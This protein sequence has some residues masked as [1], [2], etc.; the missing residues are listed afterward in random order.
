MFELP[1][2]RGNDK[3]DLETY[4]R[5]KLADLQARTRKEDWN[6]VRRLKARD[7]SFRVRVKSTRPRST[8]KEI[9][10]TLLSTDH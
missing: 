6:S 5:L 1:F 9:K 7:V 10:L 8:A 3:L 4:K 2:R